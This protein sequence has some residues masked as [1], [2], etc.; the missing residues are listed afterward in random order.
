M[1]AV[2][3]HIHTVALER[4]VDWLGVS[5]VDHTLLSGECTRRALSQPDAL[6]GSVGQQISRLRKG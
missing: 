6:H 4:I 5:F 2:L 1:L 3:F